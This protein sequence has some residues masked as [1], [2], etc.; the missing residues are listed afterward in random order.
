M[1][2]PVQVGQLAEVPTF[3]QQMRKGLGEAAPGFKI[4]EV[5]TMQQ[6]DE[7]EESDEDIPKKS[8]AHS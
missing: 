2:I 1:T 5:N 8:S 3:R 4:V 6:S 7:E